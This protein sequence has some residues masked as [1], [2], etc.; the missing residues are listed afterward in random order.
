MNYWL[1][2]GCKEL[3]QS[4][5]FY[6]ISFIWLLLHRFGLTRSLLFCALIAIDYDINLFIKFFFQ[7]PFIYQKNSEEWFTNKR[8]ILFSCVYAVTN[9]REALRSASVSLNFLWTNFHAHLG[10]WVIASQNHMHPTH[11]P[12]HTISIYWYLS[13]LLLFLFCLFNYLVHIQ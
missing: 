1:L 7:F 2:R 13:M 5:Y 9:R 6:C 10:A 4:L 12:I 8:A 3:R 11:T